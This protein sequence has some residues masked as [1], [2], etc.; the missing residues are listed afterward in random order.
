MFSEL[1][2][3]QEYGQMKA[4]ILRYHCVRFQERDCSPRALY[5]SECP[6]DYFC[7]LR[8]NSYQINQLEFMG[9]QPKYL[10]AILVILNITHLLIGWVGRQFNLSDQRTK[11]LPEAIWLKARV[12]LKGQIKCIPLKN[13]VN[14]C[15]VKPFSFYFETLFI[16]VS[17]T[18]N[19]DFIMG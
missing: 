7:Q 8:S 5:N 14:K 16:D 2:T 11:L 19:A 12:W 13:P 18:S 4:D 10:Q 3:V 9:S 17:F 1:C 6:Q 15:F